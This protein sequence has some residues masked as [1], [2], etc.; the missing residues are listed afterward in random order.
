MDDIKIELYNIVRG[1]A[2]KHSRYINKITD[3]STIVDEY[4]SVAYLFCLERVENFNEEKGKITTYMYKVLYTNDFVFYLQ[5]K[6]NLS[7]TMARKL[8]YSFY[9]KDGKSRE[10]KNCELKKKLNVFDTKSISTD[11]D[12]ITLNDYSDS[13]EEDNIQNTMYLSDIDAEI[14]YNDVLD[15]DFNNEISTYVLNLSRLSDKNK[16]MFIDFFNGASQAELAKKYKCSRQNVNQ[17]IN[18]I[19]NK[20]KRE[21]KLT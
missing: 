7:S 8:A 11:F 18:N 3:D 13:N 21:F 1:Y 15:K 20:V 9:K 12:K 6:Y 17:V 5:A 10:E 19:Q 2:Y 16:L 14:R 4:I